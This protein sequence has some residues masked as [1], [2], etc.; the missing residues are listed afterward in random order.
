MSNVQTYPMASHSGSGASK[1][2]SFLLKE[3]DLLTLDEFV[4][5]SPLNTN[6][7]DIIREMIMPYLHAY[8]LAKLGKEW[9]FVLKSGNGMDHLINLI[10]AAESQSSPALSYSI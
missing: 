2:V 4:A 1:V 9:E 7:S 6:R 3:N 8:K 10:K 5:K